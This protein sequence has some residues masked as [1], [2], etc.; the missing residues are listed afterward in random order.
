MLYLRLLMQ[1]SLSCTRKLN[2]HC[3]MVN[4]VLKILVK[5]KLQFFFLFY[6]VLLLPVLSPL[7]ENLTKQ[8]VLWLISANCILFIA[9]LILLLFASPRWEKRIYTGI[10]VIAYLPGSIYISYLLFAHVLLQGNSIISLFETNP[11]ESKEF[12]AHYFNPWIIVGFVVYIFLCF[13]IIWKMRAVPRIKIKE[14][15]ALFVSALVGVILFLVVPP[16]SKPVYFIQFYKLFVHY[17]IRL[18]KEEKAIIA[19]QSQAY[20]VNDIDSAYQKTIVL[21]IGESL[22]R[23]HMSLYGY[24]RETNPRLASLGDSLLVY[25]DVLSPQ[26]HTIP[27]LRSVMTMADRNN[28]NNITQKP[29]LIELFNRAGY[30]TYFISTQPFGGNFKTSYDALLNLSQYSCD[31]SIENQPDEIVL[32]KFEEVLKQQTSAKQNKLIII[33]LIGNH[34]AYEFRYTPSFN[35]FNNNKD[36]MIKETEYRDKQAIH[37]I[38]KYDN[39]VLYNDDLVYKLIKTLQNK[40]KGESA[41][42]YFSDHGEEIYDMR[43]FSGHAYEKISTYMCEVPFVVWLSS[44]YRNMRSDLSIVPER[45]YS[46]GDVIFSISDLANLKYE[47]YDDTKSIFSKNFVPTERYIGNKTYDEV[48]ALQK[49]YKK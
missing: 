37:T 32:P 29:S 23:T 2:T 5:K 7:A 11:T 19:R 28:P 9:I 34:M 4:S 12:L 13:F 1:V 20:V 41:L 44:N 22:T 15:K 47:D 43:N 16:L 33:H 3:L 45:P 18:D 30:K 6:L 48:K 38:D 26:V 14:H 46:T 24:P 49:N 31:L 10:F 17:K 42:I 25:K 39:S 27:V 8:D 36:H 21:V 35:V 40:Q